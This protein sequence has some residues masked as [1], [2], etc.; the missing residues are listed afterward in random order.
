M[1]THVNIH[2]CWEVRA[3]PGGRN[4][5]V[6]PDRDHG[7]MLC[8]DL[9]GLLPY[10]QDYLAG[11]DTIYSELGPSTSI[12]NKENA[13]TDLS[14]DQSGGSISSTEIPFS[15]MTLARAK[16]TVIFTTVIF[17][18]HLPHYHLCLCVLAMWSRLAWNSKVWILPPSGLQTC[19]SL[20]VSSCPSL[21]LASC[22]LDPRLAT[23]SV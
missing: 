13:P 19:T 11:N 18:H 7:G 15:Q 14:T 16:L 1:N 5:E 4:P 3:A 12:S 6:G 17:L 10:I 22:Y 21:S 9:L 23:S 20:P 8:P 2:A